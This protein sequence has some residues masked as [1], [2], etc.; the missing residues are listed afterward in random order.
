MTQAPTVLGAPSADDDAACWREAARL[1]RE[2]PGWIV[3][4]LSRIGQYRAYKLTRGRRETT[5]TADTPA[6]LA[7]QIRRAEQAAARHTKDR[8]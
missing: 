4:W 6:A 1:R 5:L 8:P 2:H 3:L 7:E